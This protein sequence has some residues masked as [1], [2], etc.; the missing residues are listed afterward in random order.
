[1]VYLPSGSWFNCMTVWARKAGA[2]SAAVS[3]AA[4]KSGILMFSCG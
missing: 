3:M 1:M 4:I 2:A